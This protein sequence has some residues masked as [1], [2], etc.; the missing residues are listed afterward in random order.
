LGHS[1]AEGEATEGAAAPV[2]RRRKVLTAA[3]VKLVDVLNP[4]ARVHHAA[5]AEAYKKAKARLIK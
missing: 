5:F 4:H 1:A 3:D 2:K